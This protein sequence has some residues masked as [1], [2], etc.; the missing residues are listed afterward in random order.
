MDKL[1][2][3]VNYERE[4]A[5]NCCCLKSAGEELEYTLIEGF[6]FK[7]KNNKGRG[8][9][10]KTYFL[11]YNELESSHMGLQFIPHDAQKL[12]KN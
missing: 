6:P 8:G 9:N 12:R 5:E 7:K 2:L 3:L 1:A 11:F 10:K 4:E